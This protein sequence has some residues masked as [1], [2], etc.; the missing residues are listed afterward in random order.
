MRAASV[1]RRRK[2]EI[3]KKK[4]GVGEKRGIDRKEREREREK[5]TKS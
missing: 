4:G 3:K 1:E 5:S 2:E